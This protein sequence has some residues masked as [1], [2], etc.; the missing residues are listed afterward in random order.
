[1]LL[2]AQTQLRRAVSKASSFELQ[3]LVKRARKLAEDVEGAAGDETGNEAGGTA[4]AA[5]EAAVHIIKELKV[6]G[7]QLVGSFRRSPL[8][9][10]L[11]DSNR[12]C[13]SASP[14]AYARNRKSGAYVLAPIATPMSCMFLCMPAV[15]PTVGFDRCW[16]RACVR[17][18]CSCYAWTGIAAGPGDLAPPYIAQRSGQGNTSGPGGG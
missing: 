9:K 14:F 3:K 6:C 18:T 5:H 11:V 7:V 4:R 17:A 16:L 15:G 1:M 12:C 10:K 2:Q 8:R 13:R